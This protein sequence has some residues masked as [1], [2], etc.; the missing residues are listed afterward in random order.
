MWVQI[1]YFLLLFQCFSYIMLSEDKVRKLLLY[2][3]IA[4]PID[5]A[6]LLKKECCK[7]VNC[8]PTNEI[9]ELC[10]QFVSQLS[11]TRIYLFGSFAEGKNHAGSDLDF[12]IV[13]KDDGKN[14]ADLTTQA[15]RSIRRIKRRPVDIIVGT[16][17]RFEQRRL[18]PSIEN[19]VVRKGVLL[20]G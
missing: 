14:L 9:E 20:Y 12:Y 6:V 7:A 5:Y 8:M 1:D 17:D 13:V 19:E 2:Q 11:P 3:M 18:M 15:Y 16:E 4:I 10:G